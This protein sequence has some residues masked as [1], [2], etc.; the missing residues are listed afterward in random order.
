M[1]DAIITLTTDFGEASPY[2]AAVKGVILGIHGA[3]RIVDL[4][5]EIP[6]HDVRAASFFL[7]SSIVYF[8][9]GVLHVVVVDPGVGS[10][11][12]LLFVEIGGHRLLAPDN[13]CWTELARRV[14]GAPR[15]IRLEDEGYWRQPVSATFHG[16][17]ILAPVAGWLSRGL[18]PALLGPV[19]AQWTSLNLPQPELTP[20][21]LRGEVVFV[22]RFGNLITNIP[23]EPWASMAARGARIEVGAAEVAQISRTYADVAAGT[24]TALVSSSN[25]LEIAVAEGSAASRLGAKVGTRVQ[26]TATG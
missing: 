6:A 4:S 12:A 16:R 17:D 11:R 24:V 25:T 2:V 14:G 5:H 9:P 26:V 23:A 10:E 13:G 18:D 22:D 15:V 20:N 1:R 21:R 3:A 7:A 8:P 19:I